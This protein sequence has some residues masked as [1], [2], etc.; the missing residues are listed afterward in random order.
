LKKAQI[1]GLKM[2]NFFRIEMI[3]YSRVFKLDSKISDM[4]L[5]MIIFYPGFDLILLWLDFFFLKKLH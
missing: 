4:I 1:Y 2:L 3:E 5:D